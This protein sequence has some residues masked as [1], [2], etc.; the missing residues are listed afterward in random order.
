MDTKKFIKDH[1]HLI[2]SLMSLANFIL[3]YLSYQQSHERV[4]HHY[5]TSV[6]TN[7]VFYHSVVTQMVG[8]VEIKDVIAN[9]HSHQVREV[10]CGDYFYFLVSGYPRVRL[11]GR[12]YFVG[13]KTSH[14]VI[15]EIYPDRV[16]LQNG[17]HIVKQNERNIYGSNSTSRKDQ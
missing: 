2:F 7:E 11:W 10:Q 4:V 5:E 17:V 13:S 6:V 1:I 16:I 12:D 8:T 14:G 3:V 15:Y 9:G